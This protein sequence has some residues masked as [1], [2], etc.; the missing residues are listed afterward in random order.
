MYKINFQ[1]EFCAKYFRDVE[2]L[3]KIELMQSYFLK[4]LSNFNGVLGHARVEWFRG[5]CKWDWKGYRWVIWAS[6]KIEHHS[7][8][9]MKSKMGYH[10]HPAV[11]PEL[12]VLW[13]YQKTA[14]IYLNP[15]YSLSYNVAS[16]FWFGIF[17]HPFSHL[18]SNPSW[19]N[20]SSPFHQ[21]HMEI[22][23][24]A[25]YYANK[26][27]F[28]IFALFLAR[29]ENMAGLKRWVIICEGKAEIKRAIYAGD[30]CHWNESLS[31]FIAS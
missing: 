19:K 24:L 28:S 5:V 21:Q 3:P 26:N 22:S 16:Q 20:P 13:V 11:M 7:E 17:T 10:R 9:H 15:V 29:W 30:F 27:R 18:A 14:S 12:G 4:I 2:V 6:W 31:R 23:F 8:L 1:L 25:S